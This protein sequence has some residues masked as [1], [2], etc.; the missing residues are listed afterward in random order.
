MPSASSA[1]PKKSNNNEHLFKNVA[2]NQFFCY[3]YNRMKNFDALLKQVLFSLVILITALLCLVGCNQKHGPGHGT[4]DSPSFS[5]IPDV[6]LYAPS[7]AIIEYSKKK[8]EDDCYET[9]YYYCPPLDEVWRMK[10]IVDTCKDNAVIEMGECEE[11][12]E[13]IPTNEVI[14]EEEC[15]TEDGLQGVL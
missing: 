2:K 5:H 6:I 11:V 12:L 14:R 1:C 3:T 15:V 8:Y 10:V 13:C 4:N 9:W 7:D